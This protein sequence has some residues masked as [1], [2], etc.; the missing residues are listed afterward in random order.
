MGTMLMILII[1]V[2]LAICIRSRYLSIQAQ[3]TLDTFNHQLDEALKGNLVEVSYDEH[4]IS[5]IGEK[6]NRFLSMTSF[7]QEKNQEEKDGVKELVSNISHQTKTP[8]ANLTI[9]S[10]LLLEQPLPKEAEMF[11]NEIQTHTN[12]MSFLVERLMKTSYMEN[13]LINIH[14]EKISVKQLLEESLS[15]VALQGQ[16]KNLSFVGQTA[17]TNEIFCDRRWT[18]EALNNVLDNAVKYS[19]SHG[20]VSFSCEQQEFFT[21]ITIRDEGEGIPEGEQAQI[22]KR[23]FRGKGS[24]GKEGLGIG[25]FLVRKIM[26]EQNGFVKVSTPSTGGAEFSLFFPRES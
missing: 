7:Q 3:R 14:K 24:L 10:Q 18:L 23:F 11:A 26:E 2:S 6:I 21:K 20:T 1:I 8:L 15:S 16:S 12:K 17:I 4:Y 19:P 25:L 13:N 22:F 5:Q 9:Y